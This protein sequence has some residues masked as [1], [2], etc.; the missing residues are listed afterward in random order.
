MET[1]LQSRIYLILT[2]FILVVQNNVSTAQYCDSL[3]P[4]FTVDLSASPNLSWVSPSIV[5]DGN[6]CGTSA[7]DNCLEFIITL[8][9]DVIA[10]NFNIASGAIPPGALFYQVDCGPQTP[11]GSPICLSGPGPHHLTFCKPGNNS[12]TFSITSY[13]SPIIGPDITLNAACQG[14]IH[15]QYY[16]ESTIS[17]TSISPGLP[18]DYNYLLSCTAACDT[19]YITAPMSAPAF[20]DYLVCGMDV[21]SCNPNPI[22]DTIR[23]QFIAPVTLTLAASSTSICAGESAQITAVVAGGSAPYNFSWDN[24]SFAFTQNVGGG[25]YT[26]TVSDASGCLIVSD[27]LSITENALPP[28][29]AGPD[30][31]VCE[32]TLVILQ[33]SGAMSYTWT[34]GVNN[35]V[36]FYPPLGQSNYTVVGT[37]VNGCEAQDDVLVQVNLKAVVDAGPDQVVCEDTRVALTAS[38]SA[39]LQWTNGIQNGILFTQPVG[40]QTYIVYDTLP[41]GCSASDTVL[42]TVLPKPDIQADDIAACEGEPQVLLATGA[43]SYQWTPAV[44]NGVDFYP[45]NSESYQVIGTG[46]NGCIDSTTAFVEVYPLPK[47][48]FT[49]LNTDLSTSI[50]GTGFNNLS[51]GASSFNWDFGDGYSSSSFEPFHEFPNEESGTYLIT[52]TG[53]SPEGC[54]SVIEKPVQVRQDYSV[55]VPNAFTPDANGVNEV[56]LPILYGFDDQGFLLSIFNRYGELVFE[57][58]NMEVGWDGSYA[59]KYEQVQDGT[60]TWKIQA[61]VKKSTERVNLV[62]HVNV[63]K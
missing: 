54:V 29:A 30:Q 2:A 25:T 48:D 43:V 52:L 46:A 57:S 60:Y 56:F 27:I 47:V 16:D 36:A 59:G 15:A 7:P 22:C 33:G 20:V 17:W 10:I 4:S 40:Q 38:G 11:V 39:N 8:H 12:N 31:E 3:V 21:G 62:G 50:S 44:I 13:S 34:G 14:F 35:G 28:V 23:V 26:A 51:S 45:T 42:I 18:G 24:G 61:R 49:I 32:G 6:C 1:T 55:Y 53:I 19:T 37:D 41:T 5:R 58:K 9:P 63:I